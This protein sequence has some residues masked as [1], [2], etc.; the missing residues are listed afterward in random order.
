MK[1]LVTASFSFLLFACS[2][3]QPKYASGLEGQALPNFNLILKDSSTQFHTSN[4]PTGRSFII[5]LYQP[6][7]PYCRSQL[8]DILKNMAD[9]K[10]TRVYMVTTSSYLE[11]NQFFDNYHLEKYSNIILA[12]D[13]AAQFISYFN[14]SGI[15]YLAIYDKQKK[16]AKVLFGKNDITVIKNNIPN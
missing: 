13:S 16:L 10:N 7:C 15:P 6:Y 5:F 2:W 9:F 8:E 1:Q 12:R 14:A 11:L 3:P 4:I